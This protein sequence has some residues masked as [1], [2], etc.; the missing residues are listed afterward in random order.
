M[1][2]KAQRHKSILGIL[3]R[4]L[5]GS[6][7]ELAAALEARGISV[8]QPTLSRDLRELE[9]TRV[10]TA[11]G[12]RYLAAAD[13]APNGNGSPLAPERFKELA[14]LEVTAVEANEMV[15]AIRTIPGRA[16]GLA[17]FLDSQAIPELMAT[18]A[19]DDT[20]IA[21]PKRSN[22]T[23]RLRRRLSKLLGVA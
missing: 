23:R 9:I 11:Q 18:I 3:H 17:W 7:E 14:A 13:R 1:V 21:Y 20:V 15:V 2:S 19:G 22:Q 5:V 6:Q 12:Y 4:Q 16:Q 8:T 10:P